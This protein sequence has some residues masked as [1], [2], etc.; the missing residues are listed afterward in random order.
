M[1][2]QRRQAGAFQAR[3]LGW[4][5]GGSMGGLALSGLALLWIPGWQA[6]TGSL[7][8]VLF[9]AGVVGLLMQLIWRFR[10]R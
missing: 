8:S 10:R 3:I 9:G 2:R 4:I 6:A 5:W 1:M 7:G